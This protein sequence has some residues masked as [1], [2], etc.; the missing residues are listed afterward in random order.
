METYT[1]PW[2][3]RAIVCQSWTRMCGKTSSLSLK[4]AAIKILLLC[5][6][7]APL[8]KD[9]S[10]IQEIVPSTS[11]SFLKKDVR[12]LNSS[13][14]SIR[15]SKGVHSYEGAKS[16]RELYANLQLI[17]SK[18]S[19]RSVFPRCK[20]CLPFFAVKNFWSVRLESDWSKDK[21]FLITCWIFWYLRG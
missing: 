17:L 14:A 18:R 9:G 5:R 20:R 16:I 2:S 3:N 19:L 1:L 15:L 8:F 4:F 13:E 10:Q 7:L 6:S 11:G 12:L 21:L